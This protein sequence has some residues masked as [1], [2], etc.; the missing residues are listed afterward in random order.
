MFSNDSPNIYSWIY[1]C[2]DECIR[3]PS[4]IVIGGLH[5]LMV[6]EVINHNEG[7]RIQI[8][9]GIKKL[10]VKILPRQKFQNVK[11]IATLKFV[12]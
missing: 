9:M 7:I 4:V 5:E 12:V 6:K 10:L 8:Y 2:D 3:G 1:Q 11:G